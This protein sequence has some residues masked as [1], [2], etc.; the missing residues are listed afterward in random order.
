MSEKLKRTDSG[1]VLLGKLNAAGSAGP[2]SFAM[3]LEAGVPVVIEAAVSPGDVQCVESSA[4]GYPQIIMLLQTDT[5][6]ARLDEIAE[7]AEVDFPLAFKIENFSIAYGSFPG[8][9]AAGLSGSITA[10]SGAS[11]YALEVDGIGTEFD[12][13]GTTLCVLAFA[14]YPQGTTFSP[15]TD[16]VGAVRLLIFKKGDLI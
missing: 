12:L 7:I 16:G 5:I 14:T 4:G 11:E 3:L 8:G 13:S 1:E 2:L 6:H 9:T 15:V 10:I